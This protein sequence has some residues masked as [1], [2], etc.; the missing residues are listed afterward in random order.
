M[1]HVSVHEGPMLPPVEKWTPERRRARTRAALVDAARFVFA[2]K[3]FEGAS[4][5]EIAETAG[6]TRGAIYKHF[7]GKEDLLFAVYD[8][9]NEQALE[10]YSRLLTDP[11]RA[12][13]PALIVEVWEEL[14]AGD[15]DLRALELEFELYSLRHPEVR[16]RS[17]QHRRHN[18]QLV[19]EFMRAG[20]KA[21]GF[22]FAIPIDQ[23]SAI[24]LITTDAFTRQV[25]NDPEAGALYR[26][27]LERF[28]PSVVRDAQ[29]RE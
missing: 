15:S 7:R 24:L 5:D 28:L 13:D 14:I 25:D 11:A 27:F 6:Y 19:V 12:L 8:Q 16:E 20:S 18:R 26:K 17:L 3:G 10:R 23:L 9:V 21:G 1:E 4:L 29:T 22:E 2:R